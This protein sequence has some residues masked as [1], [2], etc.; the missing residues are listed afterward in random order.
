MLGMVAGTYYVYAKYETTGASPQTFYGEYPNN[1]VTVTNDNVIGIDFNTFTIQVKM[2]SALVKAGSKMLGGQ[3]ISGPLLLTLIASVYDPATDTWIS[4]ASVKVSDG[5]NT[6]GIKYDTKKQRYSYEYGVTA[7]G[8]Y[9]AVD[10][11]YTFS[12]STGT[13]WN[14]LTIPLPHHPLTQRPTITAPTA[15]QHF[16]SVQNL[17]VDWTEVTGSVPDMGMVFDAATTALPIW[18]ADLQSVSPS[19]P[20]TVPAATFTAGKGYEVDV[21]TGRTASYPG[22]NGQSIELSGDYALFSY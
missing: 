22:I 17:S 20:F 18:S 4:D 16:G 6:L 7:G 9:T 11:T 8:P 14:K 3:T 2:S 5:T 1:P 12:V 10:G 19:K 21:L 15:N 13:F